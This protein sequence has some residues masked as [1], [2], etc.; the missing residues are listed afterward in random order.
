MAGGPLVPLTLERFRSDDLQ[1]GRGEPGGVASGA[2]ANRFHDPTLAHAGRLRLYG[3]APDARRS[4]A[5]RAS[6]T[7]A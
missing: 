1:P 7:E 4:E 3:S 2:G 5:V 6:K